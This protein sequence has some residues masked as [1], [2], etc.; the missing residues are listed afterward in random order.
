MLVIVMF[1]YRARARMYGV[2][3]I[4]LVFFSLLNT[5]TLF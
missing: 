3:D 2:V 5:A 1:Y 4:C